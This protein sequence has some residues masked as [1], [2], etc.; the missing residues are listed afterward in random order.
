MRIELRKQSIPWA[1]AAGRA[2]LGP[3]LI[4]G[5]TACSWNG[6]TLAAMVVTALA[7]RYLRWRAG[8][9]LGV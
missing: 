1:M 3:V 8:A 7:L 5:Q 9:A 2:A 4:A 6:I